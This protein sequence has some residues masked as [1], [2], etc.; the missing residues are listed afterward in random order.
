MGRDFVMTDE[1]RATIRR[2]R[3]KI[4]ENADALCNEAVEQFERGRHPRACFLAMTAIEETGKLTVLRFVGHQQIKA[5]GREPTSID[6]D[7][8]MDFLRG[9]SEKSHESA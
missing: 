3:M 1:A 2:Y 4:L 6:L 7:F 8:L 5:L 9:H